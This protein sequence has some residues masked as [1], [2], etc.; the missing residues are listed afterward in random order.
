MAYITDV[1]LSEILK[2]DVVD[3]FGRKVGILRDLSIIPG[4]EHP[5]VTRLILRKGRQ[6]LEVPV[7]CLQLFNRFCNNC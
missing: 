3:Q 7:E 5:S 2:K 4:A 1:Y 6:L